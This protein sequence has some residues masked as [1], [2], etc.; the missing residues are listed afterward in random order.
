MENGVDRFFGLWSSTSA[1]KSAEQDILNTI[2]QEPKTVAKSRFTSFFAPQEEEV[3]VPQVA[4]APKPSLKPPT[5]T[6]ESSSEDREGFQRILKIL[7]G[8]SM[9]GNTDSVPAPAPA[10]SRP[11]QRSISPITSNLMSPPP[12]PSHQNQASSVPQRDPNTDFLMRLMHQSHQSQQHQAQVPPSVSPLHQHYGGPSQ[13]PPP[14]PISTSPHNYHRGKNN[15]LSPVFD[16]PAITDFRRRDA[17]PIYPRGPPLMEQHGPPAGWNPQQQQQMS[18]PPPPQ[19]LRQVAPP[20]G[21]ARNQHHQGPP[22]PPPFLGPPPLGVNGPPMPF[23]L[24]PMPPNIPPNFGPPPPFFGMNGLNGLG[25][26]PPQMNGPPP[27]GYHMPFHHHH[28]EP[29]HG[30]PMGLHGPPYGFPH[31]GVKNPP[32]PHGPGNTRFSAESIH[33]QIR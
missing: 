14:P 13:M 30:P 19:S 8:V 10:T 33:R 6:N 1:A 32:H 26:P 22:P 20:P 7:S 31:E 18:Q 23:Q 17:S 5:P 15:P 25:G 2:R 9:G 27:P 29:P 21:L 11:M 28:H 24:G 16:D 4:E 3:V 12:A